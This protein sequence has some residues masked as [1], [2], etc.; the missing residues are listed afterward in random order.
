MK[1]VI[2][3]IRLILYNCFIVIALNYFLGKSFIISS[4]LSLNSHTTFICLIGLT[5]LYY[6][7]I[8]RYK[9]NQIHFWEFAKSILIK[10]SSLAFLITWEFVLSLYMFS[11]H[12][13]PIST[14]IFLFVILM[15]FIAIN[16][17]IINKYPFP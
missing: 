1:T 6:V 8:K 7:I 15:V 2:S 12:L 3:S 16:I 5:L 10:L 13:I 9:P 14:T 4:K 11:G 17:Y